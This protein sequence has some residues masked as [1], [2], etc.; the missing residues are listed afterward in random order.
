M[1]GAGAPLDVALIVVSWNSAD[2]LSALLPSVAS[3]CEGVE[4]FEVVV[5]DNASTDSSVDVAAAAGAT[6]VSTGRNAGYAAG[7]NAAVAAAPPARAYLV[8]NPDVRLTSGAV[9]AL[10]DVLDTEPGTGIVVPRLIEPSGAVIPSLRREPTVLRAIGEA[11]LG[12]RRAGR[13]STFG[14]LV[15]DPD[16]YDV[17]GSADWASGAAMLVS[18]ECLDGVGP[19]EEDF[20]LYS[21][22]TDFA[23]RA[24]DRGFRLVYSPDATMVHVGGDV[25]VSPRLWSMLTVNRVRCYARRHGPVRT[26]MFRSAVVVNEALRA[27]R[28]ENRA[29]LA[30]LLVPSRRPPEVRGALR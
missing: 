6:V 13:W 25:H 10:L 24:R 3:G 27:R 4:R 29:A 15:V 9:R 21:E 18:R 23:L 19:W 17:Q 1:T 28:A 26:A 20:F 30:S 5:A 7:V 8:L 22:E 12:G 2:D 16:R 14:E 11:V